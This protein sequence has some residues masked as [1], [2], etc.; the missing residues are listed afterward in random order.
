M[1]LFTQQHGDPNTP[2]I[3]FLH[4]AGVSSWMWEEQ[5]QHLSKRFHCITVDLP[6]NGESYQQ[7]W[8]SLADSADQVA[9][10]IREQAA[11]SKAHLVGLSLGSYVALKLLQRHPD[12]VESVLVSGVTARPFPRQWF[13]KPLLSVMSLLSGRDVM[14]NFNIRIM[15]IPEEVQAVFIRDNKRASGQMLRQVF[16]ELLSFTLPDGLE[17]LPQRVLAVAGDHEAKL[18]LDSLL[19][20]AAKMQ[21]GE[22]RIAPNAHHAW[23]AEHPQLFTA[24]VE[25]WVECQPLPDALQPV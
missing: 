1:T 7:P 25:A 15:Q 17:R 5:V 8:V 10:I 4:G 19:D 2:T 3:V 14:I 11:G 22:A 9:V 16:S 18:I 6:G 13:Y 20:F 12:L 21:H 24:M 23:N